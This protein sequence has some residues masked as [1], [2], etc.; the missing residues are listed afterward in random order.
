M[1]DLVVVVQQL[2]THLGSVW[3]VGRDEDLVRVQPAARA[4][5]GL[6]VAVR[7]GRAEEEEERRALLAV[8]QEVLEV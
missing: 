7:L 6:V 3:Q 8:G 1:L 4:N 2:G 5:P